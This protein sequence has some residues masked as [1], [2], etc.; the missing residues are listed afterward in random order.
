[1]LRPKDWGYLRRMH[2]AQAING[3]LCELRTVSLESLNLL[4]DIVL[5]KITVSGLVAICQSA[6]LRFEEFLVEDVGY[7]DTTSLILGLVG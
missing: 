5:E 7:T 4:L 6:Q 3:I 2:K 1:M